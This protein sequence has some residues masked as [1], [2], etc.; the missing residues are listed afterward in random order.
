MRFVGLWSSTNRRIY[1]GY[2][3]AVF[4][5]EK[6]SARFVPAF[7][8][9]KPLPWKSRGRVYRTPARGCTDVS[10]VVTV[11]CHTHRTDVQTKRLVIP[12]KTSGLSYLLCP[13]GHRKTHHP[14]FFYSFHVE[15]DGADPPNPTRSACIHSVMGREEAGSCQTL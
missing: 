8:M 4:G 11:L 1:R 13:H 6:G 15:G 14:A 7:H 2:K 3:N 5:M 10:T 12:T 9:R